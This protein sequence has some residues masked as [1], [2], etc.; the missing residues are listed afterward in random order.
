M[1][2]HS[3]VFCTIK[4]RRFLFLFSGNEDGLWDKEMMKWW[5]FVAVMVYGWL[6]LIAV[7]AKWSRCCLGYEQGCNLDDFTMVFVDGLNF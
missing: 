3:D 7:W 6:Q 2:P 1:L 4:E 5:K